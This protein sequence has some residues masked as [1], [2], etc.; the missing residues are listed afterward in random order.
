[1]RIKWK[2]QT[3]S[4]VPF[5]DLHREVQFGLRQV[6]REKIDRVGE[7]SDDETDDDRQEP[8]RNFLFPCD[9]PRLAR[10]FLP[11]GSFGLVVFFSIIIIIIMHA[12]HEAIKEI[13]RFGHVY[14]SQNGVVNHVVIEGFELILRNDPRSFSLLHNRC[15]EKKKKKNAQPR[16][17]RKR[18][19]ICKQRKM[20]PGNSIHEFQSRA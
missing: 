18:E 19:S 20:S 14:F 13:A 9:R 16:K 8:S 11:F 5:H 4:L 7:H 1:M 12:R 17:M 6:F 15:L 10:K 2:N 3:K